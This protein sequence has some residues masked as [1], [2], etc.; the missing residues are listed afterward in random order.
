MFLLLSESGHAL[1]TKKIY[2]IQFWPLS[3]FPLKVCCL[4]RIML[5]RLK[6]H[7]FIPL[8]DPICVPFKKFDIW[9]FHLIVALS[10]LITIFLILRKRFWDMVGFTIVFAVY[11][12]LVYSHLVYSIWSIPIWSIPTWSTLEK[13]DKWKD[14]IVTHI[15]KRSLR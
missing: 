8:L 4:S 15:R 13:W 2:V 1:Y 3:V 11:S 12:H 10:K 7:S 6:Q 5:S 14:R 9:H